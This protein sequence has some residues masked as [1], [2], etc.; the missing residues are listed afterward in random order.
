MIVIGVTLVVNLAALV[1]EGCKKYHIVLRIIRRCK[2]IARW[3]NNSRTQIY[4]ENKTP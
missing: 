2:I 3:Y 4:V 1:V